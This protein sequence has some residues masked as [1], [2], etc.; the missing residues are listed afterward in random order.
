MKCLLQL[1]CLEAGWWKH[2]LKIFSYFPHCVPLFLSSYPVSFSPLTT[3]WWM[4]QPCHP[5]RLHRPQ[6]KG[7]ASHL[8]HLMWRAVQHGPRAQG[9]APLWPRCRTVSAKWSV[10]STH[11]LLAGAP[12]CDEWWCWGLKVSS[13]LI[14][15]LPL[16]EPKRT[17][18]WPMSWEAPTLLPGVQ[19]RTGD[20]WTVD[21]CT[22]CRCQVK[23]STDWNT[24]G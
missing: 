14:T 1:G 10:V 16:L 19:Y 3:M 2:H 11:R 7:P 15:F 18:S 8:W 20:E 13:M 21:S 4:G 17:K 12:A 6:D 9:L 22:E 23:L 24:N 5:H